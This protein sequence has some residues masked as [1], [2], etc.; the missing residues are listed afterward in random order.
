MVLQ[1]GEMVVKPDEETNNDRRLKALE[2]QINQLKSLFLLNEGAILHKIK[3][4]D[5]LNGLGRIRTGD[6]RR[7]KTEVLEHA[8][9]FLHP[10]SAPFDR[11][12]GSTTTKNASN[13]LCSV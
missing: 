8:K 9:S 2:L 13:P 4:E 1:P 11:S 12:V 3:K 7:V 10:S 6:L 5:E